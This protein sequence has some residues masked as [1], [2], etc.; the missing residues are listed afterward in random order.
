MIGAAVFY[1]VD[2]RMQNT[3]NGLSL[4]CDARPRRAFSIAARGSVQTVTDPAVGRA[5]ATSRGGAGR[6]GTECLMMRRLPVH[7]LR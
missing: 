3:I 5:W 7:F 1:R 6:V 4:D 2:E